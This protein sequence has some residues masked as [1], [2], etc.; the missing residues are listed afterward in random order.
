MTQQ[1]GYCVWFTGLSGSGKSTT[2]NALK[3]ELERHGR[4]VTLLDGDEFREL[5]D[6]GF[7]K[8]DRDKNILRI[9]YV[10]REIV[11]HDGI[12]IVAA[13]S[14]Y[15]EMRDYV[16]RTIGSFIEVYID[17]PLDVCEARDA[18]G[19]YAKVRRGEIL[20][21][22]GI[23]DPYEEP[24][25]PELIIHNDQ[26]SVS[27]IMK[28]LTPKSQ[29]AAL[30]IGRWQVPGVHP[31]HVAL[32]RKAL[33][34]EGYVAIGVRDTYSSDDPKNPFTF[35]QIKDAIDQTLIEYQDQYKVIKLPNIT[36]VIY[37]RDAGYKVTQIHLESEIE[38]ISATSLR[39]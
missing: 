6:L 2:A 28:L 25:Q 13:I 33:D 10:A 7:S 38:A 36:N 22:T 21:F 4:R 30:L 1:D 27:L 29:S 39:N 9:A 18:K 24:L 26:D 17:T 32:F 14:P 34:M 23:D 8:E 5:F 31:G 16:R 3:T 12:A 15:R 19:L 11:R 35:A 37:G 20:G